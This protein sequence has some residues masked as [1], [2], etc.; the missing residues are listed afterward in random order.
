MVIYV[1]YMGFE[2][3]ETIFTQKSHL[4]PIQTCIS[5]RVIWVTSK[6]INTDKNITLVDVIIVILGT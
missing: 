3:S 4:E 1:S 5:I 2:K 6:Q